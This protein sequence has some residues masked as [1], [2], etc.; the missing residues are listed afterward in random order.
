MKI[1]KHI[2]NIIIGKPIVNADSMFGINEK[3]EVWEE[4][5]QK[6][7]WT[8]E[9]S[10]PKIIGGEF[11]AAWFEGDKFNH[12]TISLE[13]AKSA[14]EVR[15]NRKDLNITLEHL[16][17]IEIKWGKHKLYILIGDQPMPLNE[18]DLLKE[19]NTY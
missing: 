3:P 14:S 7:L 10:L 17:Y 11:E 4:E 12:D 2:E 19:L 8:N 9:R 6:T 18:D 1:P 13:F 5:K 15:R 16:D